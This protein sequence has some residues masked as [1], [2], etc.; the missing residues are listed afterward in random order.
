MV[1]NW[2]QACADLPGMNDP[3][4]LVALIYAVLAEPVQVLEVS[5]PESSPCC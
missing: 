4:D 3:H 5:P 2:R 1:R